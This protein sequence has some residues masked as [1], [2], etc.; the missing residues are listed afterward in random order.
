MGFTVT[1]MQLV[2]L[3]IFLD[4]VQ[5]LARRQRGR[6]PDL[7][8]LSLIKRIHLIRETMYDEEGFPHEMNRLIGDKH[9]SIKRARKRRH[10]E[11]NTKP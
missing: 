11:R 4:D 1:D 5:E 9:A 3:D 7:L 2:S 8:E 6:S 10:A